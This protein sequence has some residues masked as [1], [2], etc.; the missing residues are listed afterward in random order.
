MLNNTRPLFIV[1][2]GLSET[3]P[4]RANKTKLFVAGWFL[5]KNVVKLLSNACNLRHVRQ[6]PVSSKD[7]RLFRM[8]F[9]V[10]HWNLGCYELDTRWHLRSFAGSQSRPW[11]I[12]LFLRR[13]ISVS[14][15]FIVM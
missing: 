7:D 1:M 14:V 10:N 3:K 4:W 2:Q 12:Y 8:H 11:Q 5:G 13:H 15:S 9:N 6:Q